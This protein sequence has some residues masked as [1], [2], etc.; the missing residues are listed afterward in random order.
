VEVVRRRISDPDIITILS[1]SSQSCKEL[2]TF[3]MMD[4]RAI[5]RHL[6][7][8]CRK[9]LVVRKR[10]MKGDARRMIYSASPKRNNDN[11]IL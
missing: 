11:I 10:L 3:L 4:P 8:L 2:A 9:G 7:A 5:G 6:T 1:L